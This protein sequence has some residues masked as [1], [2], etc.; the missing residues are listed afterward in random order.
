MKTTNV[1]MK[2]GALLA[3]VG[4][5]F[6]AGCS[7][8][9]LNSAPQAAAPSNQLRVVIEGAGVNA[10]TTGPTAV[11]LVYTYQVNEENEEELTD[12]AGDITFATDDSYTIVFRAR[13]VSITGAIVAEKTIAVTVADSLI[14]GTGIEGNALTVTF[15]TTD[16]TTGNG[17]LSFTGVTFTD[18]TG[19]TIT[20]F[21]SAGVVVDSLDGD[22][23]TDGEYEV[24][25]AEPTVPDVAL[26]AGRYIVEIKLE[27]SGNDVAYYNEVAVIWAGLTTTLTFDA[28]G[29]YGDISATDAVAYVTSSDDITGTIGVAIDGVDIVIKLFNGTFAV[30]DQ[31]DDLIEWF[32]NLP[33]GLT[34][35]AKDN[36]AEGDQAIT[37]TVAGITSD[38]TEA[39]AVEI[40]IPDSVVTSAIEVINDTVTVEISLAGIAAAVPSSTAFTDVEID[41]IGDDTIEITLDNATF[42]ADVP[43]YLYFATDILTVD[44][45]ETT[46]AIGTVTISSTP[47]E[48]ATFSVTEAV[49][50]AGTT[51]VAV[52]GAALATN[53]GGT[54]IGG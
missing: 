15:E 32:T 29:K 30:I 11:A 44:T 43:L 13:A 31:D 34:A 16:L 33:D 54:V 49:T 8:G 9:L 26:P 21:T 2:I 46:D 45:N 3:T 19:G 12:G 24:E 10:R 38:V 39:T 18:A 52:A 23:W 7:S 5:L 37:I 42:K 25:D 22:G 41:G 1:K 6:L 48:T 35:V 14:S 17:T 51:K 53:S 36:V 40:T 50:T 4:I 27:D 28:N 20:V 47:N